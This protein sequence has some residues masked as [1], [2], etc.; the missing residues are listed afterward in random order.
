MVAVLND[1]I[2]PESIV[3][4]N[5]RGSQQRKNVRASNQAGFVKANIVWRD[6]LRRFELGFAPMF[7]SDWQAIEG[8]FEVTEGGAYG[9]LM[10]DPKDSNAAEAAGLPMPYAGG[11]VGA[12]GFGYGVPTYHLYK[13]YSVVGSA[14]TKDRRITRPFEVTVK[15]GGVAVT[16]G[17]GAGQI[18]ID[19]DT[20]IVTFVA[21]AASAVSSVTVGATTQV[22]LAGAISGLIVGKRLY[23]SGLTGADAALLNGLSHAITAVASSTYTVSTNT[24][25]KTITAGSGVGAKYPQASEALAWSGG[26]YV[27]VQFESDSIDWETLA[28]GEEDDRLFAGRSIS[29]VEVRES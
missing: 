14:R 17:A 18:D 6:T 25:G 27:P 16:E 26:F 10:R 13:R 3:E 29:L 12:I 5:V 23:L 7:V 8:L 28:S 22:T 19:T 2:L 21:D 9:F 1:V 11:E 20:G 15:R 4:G 24:A